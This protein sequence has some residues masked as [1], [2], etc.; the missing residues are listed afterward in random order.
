[1]KQTLKLSA[2]VVALASPT[3]PGAIQTAA[4][5]Q[6]TTPAP[7]AGQPAATTPATPPPAPVVVW[8]RE[9]AQELLTYAEQIGEEG[10]DPAAYNLD[11]LRQALSTGDDAAI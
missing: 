4:F 6:D 9:A 5:A 7:A 1:M 3:M 11:R 8:R 10:L 2:L